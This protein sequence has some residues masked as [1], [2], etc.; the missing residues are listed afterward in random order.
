MAGDVSAV[1]MF[2][3]MEESEDLIMNVATQVTSEVHLIF[4]G[5]AHLAFFSF[6]SGL[7]VRCLL[8]PLTFYTVFFFVQVIKWFFW[9]LIDF[10]QALVAS[11]ALCI[12]TF[13]VSAFIQVY[14]GSSRYF[15]KPRGHIIPHP[16]LLA[17]WVSSPSMGTPTN[18]LVV[19]N[20]ATSVQ[21]VLL[22]VTF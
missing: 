12:C 11:M 10:L 6:E 14:P 1:A 5:A 8:G 7:L 4:L 17:Y 15:E 13:N 21:E 3:V 20:L 16:L 22:Q 18:L 9:D 2:L 19:C